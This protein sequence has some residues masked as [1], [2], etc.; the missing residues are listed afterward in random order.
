RIISSP[1]ELELLEELDEL[2][3]EGSVVL[4]DPLS[5]IGYA[6]VLGDV[7]SVF[8]QFT[9]RSLDRDGTFLAEHFADIHEDVRVC[10]VLRHY[11]IGYYYEDEPVQ[12]EGES[13]EIGLPGLY[14]VDT[15][16]GFTPIASADGATL[17]RVDACGEID[18][19]ED[20]WQ[21]DWRGG[22]VTGRRAPPGCRGP[23]AH[24]TRRRG[25]ARP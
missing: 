2:V 24:R 17:W 23:T 7:D 12:Y 16:G 1:Q 13:R 19:R 25:R 20:W 8:T 11:G 6:P 10:T 9:T 3:P 14:D 21:E 5:G 15:S 4:G 18:P 22:T